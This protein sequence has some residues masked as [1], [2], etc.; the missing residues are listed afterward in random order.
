MQSLPFIIRNK[1]HLDSSSASTT[2]IITCNKWRSNKNNPPPEEIEKTSKNLKS[3]DELENQDYQVEEKMNNTTEN[4]FID[5][6]LM[7]KLSLPLQTEDKTLCKG[8]M[9]DSTDD[10]FIDA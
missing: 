1:Q 8:I 2:A 7:N 3:D 5:V 10:D 9:D 6:P 4:Y